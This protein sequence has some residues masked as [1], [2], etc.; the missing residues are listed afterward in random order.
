MINPKIFIGPMSKNIV[1]SIIK[2]SNENNVEIGLIPSRRQ[3]EFDGGYVNNWTT[4]EFCEYVRSKSNK[5]LLVRDHAGPSQGYSDDNGVDS[6]VEDCKHF[7]IVHV[8]VWKKH[9]EYREGLTA[10]VE[11]IL[12]GY[13]LNPNLLYEVGTEEAIRPF[14]VDEIDMLITDL[15][16]NL[17]DEMYSKIKYV[18]IQSGTALLGNKNIGEYKSDKLVQ[19]IDVCNKHGLISKEH[20][21]DY[22][23]DVVLNNKFKNG[24]DSINIAPEF[25]Q[26]ETKIILNQIKG[27]DVLFNELYNICYDSKR[28][29]KWVPKDFD[30]V[31]NKEDV[32]N[33]SGHYIFSDPRFLEMKKS[34]FPDIDERIKLAIYQRIDRFVKNSSV[35]NIDTIKKYFVNFE[36]KNLEGLKRL[37][38]DDVT[39]SDWNISAKGLHDVMNANSNIFNSVSSIKIIQNTTYQDK[40]NKKFACD[41]SIVINGSETLDVVDLI[42]FDGN[43]KIKRVNAYKK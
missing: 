23:D 16:N 43:G 1:D 14:S 41:I 4:E 29:L 21:G 42:E 28:W 22:L 37:F 18:V 6:F 39:L 15:K 33:I 13:S 25:G 20:N 26:I 27:N 34:F 11:F 24:L 10:T 30:P 19:M 17:S 12:K 38:S 32:I 7:D 3:V 40:N 31:K 35:N 5:I 2:Y 8:D 36:N 9:K